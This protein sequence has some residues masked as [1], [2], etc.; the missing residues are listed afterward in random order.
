MFVAAGLVLSACSKENEQ[1][2]REKILAQMEDPCFMRDLAYAVLADEAGL[3]PDL[4]AKDAELVLERLVD[5][6]TALDREAIVAKYGDSGQI[7]EALGSLEA[8]N[9]S[10]DVEGCG[11]PSVSEKLTLFRQIRERDAAL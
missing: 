3:V 9:A 11:P 1:L 10:S 4:T 7:T 6:T 8:I 5:D 2:D